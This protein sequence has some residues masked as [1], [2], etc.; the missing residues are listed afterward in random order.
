MFVAC[1]YSSTYVTTCNSIVFE[2][3]SV[4]T[5]KRIKT[6]GWTGIDGAM[7]FRWQRNRSSVGKAW[8]QCRWFSNN[9]N[10][11]GVPRHIKFVSQLQRWR[12]ERRP[13]IRSEITV[14]RY[15]NNI[16]LAQCFLHTYHSS[17][18]VKNNKNTRNENSQPSI[19]DELRGVSSGYETLCR[20]TT[21]NCCFNKSY[22]SLL[23]HLLN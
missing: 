5:Q 14:D 20:I 10:S 12:A 23:R 22:A 11:S 16:N 2:R 3:F 9:M 7:R 15:H 8:E 21:T 6:V 4:D 13:Q 18:S 1:A 17:P 19:F